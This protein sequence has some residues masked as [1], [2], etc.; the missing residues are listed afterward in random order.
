MFFQRQTGSTA[1]RDRF[2]H[3]D[4]LIYVPVNMQFLL[5]CQKVLWVGAQSVGSKRVTRAR[6][7]QRG[8]FA[9]SATATGVVLEPECGMTR[10]EADPLWR[11]RDSR[12]LVGG[13]QE[14]ATAAVRAEIQGQRERPLRDGTGQAWRPISRPDMT[15]ALPDCALFCFLLNKNSQELSPFPLLSEDSPTSPLTCFL[16]PCHSLSPLPSTFRYTWVSLSL[17]AFVL[18]GQF[19][20]SPRGSTFPWG[21]DLSKESLGIS[22]RQGHPR[23][24]LLS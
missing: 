22:E 11:P 9:H 7:P 3:Q 20:L 14:G 10:D 19:Y 15:P 13:E 5:V 18:L 17:T 21:R 12:R 6:S 2:V 23:C 24:S 8:P 4:P 16:T 1:K